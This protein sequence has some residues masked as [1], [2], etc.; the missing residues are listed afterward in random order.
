MLIT[1]HC[2]C[3][4][5]ILHKAFITPTGWM[6]CTRGTE[7][8]RGKMCLCFTT[9]VP[10]SGPVN[11]TGTN[12]EPQSLSSV[13]QAIISFIY[14]Q[15]NSSIGISD[16]VKI[17]TRGFCVCVKFFYSFQWSCNFT[18]SLGSNDSG[19]TFIYKTLLTQTNIAAH[20]P[21]LL[22]L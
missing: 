6:Y 14:L 11:R 17:N 16:K 22:P 7:L 13:P 2:K 19:V 20:S 8:Y 18:S 9:S 1:P 21:E 15:N 12:K 5:I 4:S 3:F 10:P